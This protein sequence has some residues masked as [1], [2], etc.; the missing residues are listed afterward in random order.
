MN[1]QGILAPSNESKSSDALAAKRNET[2]R[3][4][5][6]LTLLVGLL[7]VLADQASKIWAKSSLADGSKKE[8]LGDFFALELSYN[9]GAAFSF[10]AGSTW[11]FTVVSVM[12]VAALLWISWCTRSWI[13]AL[14]LGFVGGGGV[15]NLLDRLLQPPAFG[16]GYVIDFL[17]YNDWFIGNVAD[18]W[19]VGGVIAL[20][21]YWLTEGGRVQN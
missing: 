19:I 9:S 14:I 1:E 4:W 12:V 16:S 5:W 2:S 17:N 18:I 6:W 15:G 21:I 20:A 11:V 3:R 10:L 13:L 7:C 8:L